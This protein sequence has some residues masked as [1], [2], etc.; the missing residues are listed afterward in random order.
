[1]VPVRDGFFSGCA[2]DKIAGQMTIWRQKIL[3]RQKKIAKTSTTITKG[4]QIQVTPR[5]KTFPR[6][7]VGLMAHRTKDLEWS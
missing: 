2:A 3:P 4:R 1:M 5:Q 7:S 6:G